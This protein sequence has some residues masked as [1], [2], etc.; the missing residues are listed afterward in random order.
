MINPEEMVEKCAEEGMDPEIAKGMSP[1]QLQAVLVALEKKKKDKEDDDNDPNR[2]RDE[3][4]PMEEDDEEKWPKPANEEEQQHFRE[5]ARKYAERAK[6]FSSLYDPDEPDRNMGQ[7]QRHRTDGDQQHL[8][9]S[10]MSRSPVKM[11]EQRDSSRKQGAQQ[12]G[13]L[14]TIIR[15]EVTRAV[16]AATGAQAAQVNEVRKFNEDTAATAKKN[17]VDAVIDELSRA[18]KLPPA[19]REAERRGL[20]LADH[21]TVHKFSEGGKE[22]ARTAYEDRVAQLR[23]RPSLFAEKIAGRPQ[24]AQDRDSQISVLKG[25]FEAFSEDFQRVGMTEEKLIKGFEIERERNP[26][27][28]AKEYLNQR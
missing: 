10:Q 20:L 3:P 19:E 6:K 13:Y 11:S 24:T 9:D 21:V 5:R 7:E 25:E 16:K 12:G 17:N 26:K 1:E 22:V 14:A 18:G 4:S 27:L 2:R 8:D 28:T 15:E 23:R